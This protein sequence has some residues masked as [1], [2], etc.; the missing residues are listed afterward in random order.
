MYGHLR[1]N[2]LPGPAAERAKREAEERAK[3]Q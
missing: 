3:E 2:P 1:K